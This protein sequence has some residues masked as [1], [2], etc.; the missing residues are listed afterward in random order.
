MRYDGQRDVAEAWI[1]HNVRIHETPVPWQSILRSQQ[2]LHQNLDPSLQKSS[3]TSEKLDGSDKGCPLVS[4]VKGMTFILIK[5]PRVYDLQSVHANAPA[6]N[7]SAIQVD[8]GWTS[9]TAPYYYAIE[10]EDCEKRQTTLRARMVEPFVGEDPATGSAAC[11]LGAY[12]ALQR[13]E[14]GKT[15]TFSINQGVEMGRASRIGVSVTLD[16]SGGQIHEVQLSGTA[17]LASRGTLMT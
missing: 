6:I 12:L 11:T 9:F 8:E 13:A 17:V 3:E 5:L 14:G 7:E 1:P 4:I 16:E 2:S 15:Y 10:S